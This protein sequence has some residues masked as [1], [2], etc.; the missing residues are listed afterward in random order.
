MVKGASQVGSTYGDGDYILSLLLAAVVMRLGYVITCRYC[1]VSRGCLAGLRRRFAGSPLVS[2][3]FLAPASNKLWLVGKF[4][5]FIRAIGSVVIKI[6][7]LGISCQIRVR[8][9]GHVNTYDI[10]P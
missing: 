7:I 3:A 5:R 10:V 2:F 4:S 8:G 9:N 6:D 1:C